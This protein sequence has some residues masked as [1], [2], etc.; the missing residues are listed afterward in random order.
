MREE[1]VL[2]IREQC[3]EAGIPFFFKQWGVFVRR[4]AA[5]SCRARLMMNIRNESS[6]PCYLPI[7]VFNTPLKLMQAW[8]E[9]VR[10]D[11]NF[12]Q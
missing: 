9:L 1:W 11:P 3:R 5:E 10:V 4:A 12:T 6:T 2:S 7:C 8:I